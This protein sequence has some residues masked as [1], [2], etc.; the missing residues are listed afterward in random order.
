MRVGIIGGTGW[1]GGALGRSLVDKKLAEVI[2]LNRRGPQD[3]G[4][5]AVVWANDLADLVAQSDVIVV[6]VRPED[7]AGL[8]LQAPGKLVISFMAG[9]GLSTLAQCGGR[10]LRAMPNASAE[11]GAS[12]SPW[13]AG[14]GVTAED[15]A[16]AARVLGAI[17]SQEELPE[18]AQLEVMTALS[19]SGPAYPALLA[20]AMLAFLAERGVAPDVAAR[21][22]EATVCASARLL[23]GKVAEAPALVQTFI[24]YRG[25]TCAGLETAEAKGFS[26]AVAAALSAATDKALA[27]RQANAQ[28]AG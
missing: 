8:Q 3:Y 16:A 22:V 4:G 26:A 11:I 5:R 10:V 24:D 15:R 27:M 18:E 13:V 6:S 28:A 14:A 1:L 19:G 9:V 2:L 21:A 12:Y 25:T 20:Q 17:G 7:W 23:E